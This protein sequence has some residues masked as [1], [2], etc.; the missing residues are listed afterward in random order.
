MTSQTRHRSLTVNGGLNAPPRD[1]VVRRIFPR[2]PNLRVWAS[3]PLAQVRIN[4]GQIRLA[5]RRLVPRLARPL[6]AAAEAIDVD[7]VQQTLRRGVRFTLSDGAWWVIWTRRSHDVLAAA[8]AHGAS[9][10]R[11]PATHLSRA[12]IIGR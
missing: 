9:V 10:V 1:G 4:D 11:G 8:E 5:E 2:R 3:S 7:L 6:N 12:E